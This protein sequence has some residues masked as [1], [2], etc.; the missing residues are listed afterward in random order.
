MHFG[1]VQGRRV[2]SNYM[3][4]TYERVASDGQIIEAK[5]FPTINENTTKYVFTSE[6]GLLS[7]TQFT[8]PALGLMEL[9]IMADL[10][11]RQLIPS[12]VTFAGHSLGEYSALMAVGHI[13]PLEVFIS[14]VFYRGLVMQSTVT[15]DH[16]RSKYAMCA[17]DP[18][19]VSTGMDHGMGVIRCIAY[20]EL[21]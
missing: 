3:A 12:N 20:D 16:G 17:V 19:R 21:T 4:L 15:Y 6:S 18:T 13:M 1:G 8:Q 2:R 5:L 10:E 9:A 11:A 7:S 14:T